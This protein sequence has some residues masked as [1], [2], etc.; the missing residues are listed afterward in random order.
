MSNPIND[1]KSGAAAVRAAGAAAVNDAAAQVEASLKAQ[2]DAGEA[3]VRRHKGV[4]LGVFCVL[5]AGL[6]LALVL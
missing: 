3:W 6:I 1:L 2:S 5:L 4:V